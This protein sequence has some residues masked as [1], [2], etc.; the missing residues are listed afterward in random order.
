MAANFGREINVFV[1]FLAYPGVNS[2]VFV[3]WHGVSE[4]GSA[5]DAPVK[6]ITHAE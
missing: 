4:V 3:W 5:F 2:D 6:A 1:M